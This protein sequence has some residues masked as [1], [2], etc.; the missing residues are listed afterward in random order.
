VLDKLFAYINKIRTAI[1]A[2]NDG[3]NDADRFQ[4]MTK[5]LYGIL[6]TTTDANDKIM[7]AVEKPPQRSTGKFRG[8]KPG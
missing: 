8:P 5:Q 7:G 6:E 3:E 2:L 4:L 1:V